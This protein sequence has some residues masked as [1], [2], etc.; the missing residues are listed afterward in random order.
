MEEKTKETTILDTFKREIESRARIFRYVTGAIMILIC[1]AISVYFA[2]YPDLLS[3]KYD[4]GTTIIGLALLVI[5]SSI[6]D[7]VSRT[8]A[9][10]AAIDRYIRLDKER[11]SHNMLDEFYGNYGNKL[12]YEQSKRQIIVACMCLG[13]TVIFIIAC[14]FGIKELI[15]EYWLRITLLSVVG[16]ISLL[17]ILIQYTLLKTAI[18]NVFLMGMC[19]NTEKFL[20][21]ASKANKE[22]KDEH[23]E[24]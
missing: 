8:W 13:S 10:G 18:Q 19:V 20:L 14:A 1:Y 7:M 6:T 24:S 16:V 9:T 23:R 12:Q 2:K 17:Y 4:L 21:Q 15:L 22:D 11:N 5:P 3:L